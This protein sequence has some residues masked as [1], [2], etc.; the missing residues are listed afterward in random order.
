MEKE[1]RGG[2]RKSKLCSLLFTVPLVRDSKQ[3]LR[4]F[5]DLALCVSVGL[6]SPAKPC[7]NPLWCAANRL[8]LPAIHFL[9]VFILSLSL[10]ILSSLSSLLLNPR[11][12]ALFASGPKI[13][14]KG[15]SFSS[16]C[17]E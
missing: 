1:N 4:N 16:G 9:Y 3:C 15:P 10:L 17:V 12:V 5:L 11:A 14:E 8:N 6:S 7:L 2:R 13:K